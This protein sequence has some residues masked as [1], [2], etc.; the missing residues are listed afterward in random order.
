MIRID[1]DV[2]FGAPATCDTR[3]QCGAATLRGDEHGDLHRLRFVA[4][5]VR[6]ARNAHAMAKPVRREAR[7]VRT[8][9]ELAECAAVLR[10]LIE[11][12]EG[13]L[14]MLETMLKETPRRN[15]SV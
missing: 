2:P 13:A 15:R 6:T 9:T 1:V 5:S 3:D 4:I 8:A 7:S 11:V 12:V 10:R 14:T